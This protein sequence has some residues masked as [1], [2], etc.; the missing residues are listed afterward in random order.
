MN[1]DSTLYGGGDMGN[2]GRVRADPLPWMGQPASVELVLPPLALLVL[3][4][5]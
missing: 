2:G 1:S 5:A 4:P 3:M